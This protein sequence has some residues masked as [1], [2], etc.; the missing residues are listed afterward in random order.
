L[1][2][3]VAYNEKYR[4]RLT[5]GGKEYISNNHSMGLEKETY[6]SVVRTLMN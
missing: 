2:K 1:A 3:Q 4:D 5:L 6:K